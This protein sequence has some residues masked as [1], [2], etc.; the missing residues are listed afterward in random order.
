M[1]MG[2]LRPGRWTSLLVLMA[3]CAVAAGVIVG[4][5]NRGGPATNVTIT[6][7]VT[8][9]DEAT[10]DHA[11]QLLISHCMQQ[12]GFTF[13]PGRI[14]SAV[15]RRFPYVVDDIDWATQYGYGS[16]VSRAQA[17]A[18][19]ADPN[20]RYFAALPPYQQRGAGRVEWRA[21]GRADSPDTGCRNNPGQRPELP[22]RR[23]TAPLR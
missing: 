9:A 22:R 3:V 19:Q 5:A 4:G 23:P 21:S 17:E 7:P 2:D 12:Q 16:S 13:V 14:R 10:L 1:M 8:A 6:P 20:R 18:R 11:E 15:D